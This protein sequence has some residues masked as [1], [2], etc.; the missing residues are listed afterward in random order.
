MSEKIDFLV[1]LPGAVKA[2]SPRVTLGLEVNQTWK[3]RDTLFTVTVVEKIERADGRHFFKVRRELD[4]LSTYRVLDNGTSIDHTTERFDLTERVTRVYVAGPMS[5]HADLNF[6]AFNAAAAEYRRRGCFV[7][8]PA[9]INGG[10][11]EIAH[12]AD[13][14]DEQYQAHWRKC[15]HRDIAQLITCDTIVML[16]GWTKSRGANLEHH[17]ARELG[18]TI[19]Y[20]VDTFKT[21]QSCCGKEIQ[22]YSGGCDICGAAC[23]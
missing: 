4:F 16:D 7:V 12:T 19:C 3:T 2:A 13:M 9:E 10:E 5:G 18:F 11:I 22:N 14:S 21:A 23:V 17:I 15:M 6:P 1:G 8:N 20:P